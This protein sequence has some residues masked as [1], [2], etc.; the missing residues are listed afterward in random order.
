M[1]SIPV[2]WDAGPLGSVGE[3]CA[4]IGRNTGNPGAPGEPGVRHPDQQDEEFAVT[5]DG[6]LANESA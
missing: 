2:V 5:E 1:C 4:E 6:L 3:F